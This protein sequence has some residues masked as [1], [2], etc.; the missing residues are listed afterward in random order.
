MEAKN[1]ANASYAW[2]SILKGRDVI[3]RGAIWRI[4]SGLSVNVWG[5]NWL[6]TKH[7][8]RT[9]TP[10]VV[11]WE[12]AK[13][14]DF[15]DQR[16]RIWKTDLV[17]AIFYDFEASIIKNIPLCRSIQ[18]DVLIWPFT[19]DENYTVKSDYRFLQEAS[20]VQQPGQSSTQ[21]LSPLWNKI[22]AL[23]VPNKVKTLIWRACKNS[24][25]TKAN[26]FRCKIT[27]DGRCEICKQ[28]DEDVLHALYCCPALQSLG[29]SIPAW[30]QSSLK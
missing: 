28:E 27:P 3:K 5:E 22:W 10:V 24:L 15:I 16:Q 18:D 21:A 7:N 11:G 29:N 30:N 26:L 8:P 17:E 13:V 4:R 1:P 9:I 25:P 12:G 20:R 6:P 19:P 2:K 14:G 23:D